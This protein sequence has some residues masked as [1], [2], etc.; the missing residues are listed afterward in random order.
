[1]ITHS[2]ALEA[3][4]YDGCNLVWRIKASR[5]TVIG[6]VAGSFDADGYV[7][8]K[9]DG[10]RYPA[11]RLVWLY[12]KGEFPKGEIDH[13]NGVKADNRI[14]N[15]RDATHAENQQNQRRAHR[16]NKVGLLGVTRYKGKPR[17]TILVGG[18]QVFLGSFAT[19]AD[20]HH[21]YLTAK[22]KLHKFQTLVAQ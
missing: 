5:K 11:H 6:T 17:A 4:E 12:V 13:R 9:I 15:L 19:E 10:R 8:V 16:N 14:G 7:V 21:A 22:A 3:F 1:M 20:A 18:R 2:R